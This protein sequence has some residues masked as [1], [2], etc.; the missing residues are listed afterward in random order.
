VKPACF[1]F[2][3]DPSPAIARF[4]NECALEISAIEDDKSARMSRAGNRLRIRTQA[5]LSAALVSLCLIDADYWRS[6]CCINR[7]R[8]C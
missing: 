1:D 4:P 7:V 3:L 8:I 2:L 5:A 6:Q